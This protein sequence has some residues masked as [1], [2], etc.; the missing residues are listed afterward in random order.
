MTQKRRDNYGTEFSDWLREQPEIDSSLGFVATNIDY[1]WTN[2]KSGLW[3]LI[4]EK[5]HKQ[6]PKFYQSKAFKIVDK[7]ARLSSTYRGFHILVFSHT[8]PDDGPMFLDDKFISRADLFEFLRFEKDENW[9]ASWY[10]EGIT[11][12][13]DFSRCEI[14]EAYTIG[15]NFQ[16][17]FPYLAKAHEHTKNI[18]NK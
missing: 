15:N 7:S 8:C 2:Y 9:Y 17:E 1:F 4:E 10:A 6:L 18:W 16:N 5:R 13:V 3:M 14:K 11:G 12:P